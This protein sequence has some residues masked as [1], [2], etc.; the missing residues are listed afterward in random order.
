MLLRL[1]YTGSP[2]WLGGDEEAQLERADLVERE[3]GARWSV[4]GACPAAASVTPRSDALAAPSG[5][6]READRG[7]RAC[8]KATAPCHG[9]GL[10]ANRPLSPVSGHGRYG[11]NAASPSPRPVAAAWRLRGVATR[12]HRPVS[13]RC[14]IA[15]TPATSSAGVKLQWPWR[16]TYAWRRRRRAGALHRASVGV[17]L[18]DRYELVGDGVEVQLRHLEP[19]AGDRGLREPSH[20]GDVRA[21]VR[22]RGQRFRGPSGGRVPLGGKGPVPAAHRATARAAARSR[23]PPST[24]RCHPRPARSTADPTR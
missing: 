22:A 6:E 23:R 16:A 19:A 14:S 4:I 17:L 24:S 21:D 12:P 9:H 7:T 13:T 2:E 10:E 5:C 15:S 1:H 18:L 8:W 20:G 3:T 11:M